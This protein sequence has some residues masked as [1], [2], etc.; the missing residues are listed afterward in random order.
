MEREEAQMKAK[1][2]KQA[3]EAEA[4]AK[5]TATQRFCIMWIVDFLCNISIDNLSLPTKSGGV[6]DRR[7]LYVCAPDISERH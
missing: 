3:A 2:M 6:Y 7:C 5:R 1:S 4:E